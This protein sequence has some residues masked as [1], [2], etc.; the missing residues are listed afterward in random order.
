MVQF[1]LLF[2]M[3][4]VI[5]AVFAAV[6]IIGAGVGAALH[7]GLRA[8]EGA[9]VLSAA[10]SAGKPV[11]ARFAPFGLA[12]V[13][14]LIGVGVLSAAPIVGLAAHTAYVAYRQ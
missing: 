11:A 6:G 7:Y 9:S 5:A 3:L 10:Q 2:E 13:A 12:G 8:P 4:P 14:Y 1:A